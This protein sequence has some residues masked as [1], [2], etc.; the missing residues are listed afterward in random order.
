MAAKPTIVLLPAWGVGH[1]MPMIEAGKRMLQCC[2]SALSLTVLLMPAPTAQ[3]ESDI[4]DHIRREEEAGATDIRFLH[5]PSV[6]LPTDHT[7]VE[8]W[9]SRIVQLHVPHIRAAVSGLACPVAALVLDIFFTPALDVSRDLAVPA[10]VYFTSGAAMLA[11]LLRSP[12]LQDE[13]EGDFEG[14]VDVPGLPPLPPSFL[15]ETL[16]DKKSP[17]Y[18]WFLYTGRRY[19][20]AKGIIVNTAAELETGVLAAIAQG[21]C[22]RGVRAPTVYPIG[23]AISLI[24]PPAEQPH[25]CVRWLDSQPPSSV[26]FLCFGSKGM[27]PP[28]Q[29]HEIAHG[30]ERSGHRFLWVLR[31]LP[32]DATMGARDPTDANLAELLPEGFL[33]KTKGRGLVWPTRAPQKEILA[34]AAVGGFVTHCGWNSILESLWFGVPMLPW[35]LAADQHLNAFAVVHGMGAAVPLEMDRK[36]GNYVQAAQLERAV[37]SLM[38]GG[39][40]GV[41]A[42]EKAME[43]KRACRNAVEQSGSS[44]AS[45]QRLSEELVGGAVL[46]PKTGS[47]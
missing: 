31:G 47:T 40:E 30:L 35:P 10:Y 26:L 46:L 12:S 2:S 9:I 19:M 36:R 13:V 38:G 34:H 43:M 23:P 42:R 7:G 8:E 5:L 17:T 6:P 29:V 32:L 24:S 22:T 28:L 4:A 15:P 25:E 20:E 33:D 44:Y 1:F 27:L 21:R 37:R 3:A 45:L 16:L 18:T 41:K 11:L 39:D 14:P